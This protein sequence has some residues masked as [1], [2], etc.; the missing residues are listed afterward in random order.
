MAHSSTGKTSAVV[1]T[2]HNR[3][4]AAIV[5][6]G[7]DLPALWGAMRGSVTV[8]PGT[9]LTAPTGEVWD[10]RLRERTNAQQ[11]PSQGRLAVHHRRCPHQAQ[12]ASPECAIRHSVSDA[13]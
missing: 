10:A 3:P 8:A 6:I 11:N 7:D 12:A 1:L 5:P 9:D 2:K 13:I 4:V